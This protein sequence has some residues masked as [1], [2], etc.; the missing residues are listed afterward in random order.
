MRP[1]EIFFPEN[2]D[3]RA[4][5][6][7]VVIAFVFGLFAKLA[8]KD[9]D[10]D[11]TQLALLALLVVSAVTSQ[12]A[13]GWLSGAI[14]VL[15]DFAVPAL[16]FLLVGWNVT[17]MRRVRLMAWVFVIVGVIW[18]VMA[19]AAH[20]SGFMS[21]VLLV[22]QSVSGVEN[23]LQARHPSEDIL[24]Q[25]L[26]RVRALGFLNDSN[27]FGQYLLVCLVFVFA[28]CEKKSMVRWLLVF[29]PASSLLLIAIYL[30]H[31]RGAVVGLG[32]VLFF[33]ISMKLGK[34]KTALMFLPVVLLASGLTIGEASRGFSADE[35]SAGGR[36]EAW[37]MGLQMLKGSPLFGVG[38][39]AFL[40]H[41]G[42]TAHNSWVLCFAELGLFGYFAWN[43]LM[44]VCLLPMIRILR[45]SIKF[46]RSESYL[47]LRSVAAAT[48][49]F[50]VCSFFL[51]RTYPATHYVLLAMCVASSRIYMQSLA[52]NNASEKYQG[53]NDLVRLRL[54]DWLPKTLIL[55]VLS[56]IGFWIFTIVYWKIFG[57]AR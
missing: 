23:A 54:K 8:K 24:R 35:E 19:I 6:I 5:L 42:Y 1:F 27:D 34:L 38:Y 49:G 47:W 11:P 2:T 4:V 53:L 44:M 43:S 17:T 51:S 55:M 46:E 15:T 41:H 18:S 45:F 32:L 7:I 26:W 39:G 48:L 14:T 28:L 12:L 21:D 10:F 20:Q 40:D 57:G 33:F 56:I 16:M 37:S 50:L 3:F 29:L 13:R 9:K 52:A 36:L 30:T 25:W 31:S 22:R